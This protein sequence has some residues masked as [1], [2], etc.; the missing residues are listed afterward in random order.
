MFVVDG[1]DKWSSSSSSLVGGVFFVRVCVLNVF[2]GG[3]F[4]LVTNASV[5]LTLNG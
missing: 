1:I 4:A 2:S 5:P 3:V